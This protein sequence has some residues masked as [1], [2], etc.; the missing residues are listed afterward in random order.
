M[1]N[2]KKRRPLREDP[3]LLIMHMGAWAIVIIVVVALV[4]DEL[5]NRR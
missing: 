1:S 4:I 5:A 3:V 2:R